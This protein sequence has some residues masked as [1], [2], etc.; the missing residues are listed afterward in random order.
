MAVCFVLL[1]TINLIMKSYASPH[2]IRRYWK[3]WN[4][5]LELIVL[6]E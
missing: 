1:A 4:Q 6:E 5:L 2:A 3:S